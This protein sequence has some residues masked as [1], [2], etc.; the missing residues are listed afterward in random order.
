MHRVKTGKTRILVNCGI[1][2]EGFD[3]PLISCVML[4]IATKSLS[5]Y[6]QCIG[7]GTRPSKDTGKKN[8]IV[9]DFGKCSETH[10]YPDQDREWSLDGR[11]KRKKEY[12]ETEPKKPVEISREKYQIGKHDYGIDD[13]ISIQ[14]QKNSLQR[15]TSEKKYPKY[16]PVE[17]RAYWDE[18]EAYRKANNLPESFSEKVVRAE[19]DKAIAKG[20]NG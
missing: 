13:S 4:L 20:L 19:I 10:G 1:V 15:T 11:S 17:W 3:A 8:L 12:I 6:L 2:I 16:V 5:K 14:N 18:L 7:R 9:A